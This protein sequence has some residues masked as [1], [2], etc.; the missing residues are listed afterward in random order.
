MPIEIE[1]WIKQFES[2]PRPFSQLIGQG[3]KEVYLSGR[4]N[5]QTIKGT[6]NLIENSPLE[7]IF[8]L[9]LINPESE[10]K[11]TLV[12]DSKVRE[13]KPFLRKKIQDDLEYT[14]PE[15]TS[16]SSDLDEEVFRQLQQENLATV[17]LAQINL[18]GPNEVPVTSI[19][20]PKALM[21]ID[22]G[23]DTRAENGFYI[24]VYYLKRFNI[25]PEAYV[26]F[27]IADN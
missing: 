14:F 15:E 9:V 16:E 8:R 17:A 22:A 20:Y 26:S 6:A 12:L 19:C 10:F 1:D 27:P 4:Y 7:N 18:I 13:N 5:I 3:L 11:S 24:A 25:K 23:Y 2:S 21:N